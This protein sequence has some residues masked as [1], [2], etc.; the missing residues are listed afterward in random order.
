MTHLTPVSE[1]RANAATSASYEMLLQ[2]MGTQKFGPTVRDSVLSVAPGVRRIYLFEA[3]GRGHSAVRYFFGEQGLVDIFP[4]YRRWYLRQDPVWDACNAAPR[5]G[6]VAVQ[7]VRPADIPGGDFRRRI[8]D[9]PGI[10]ERVSVVQRGADGWRGMNVAR[11]ASDGVF[12]Q[13]EIHSLVGL[14]CLVLPMIALIRARQPDVAHLTVPE[15]EERFA[16]HCEAL[17]LRERQVCARAAVGMGV[18][19]TATELGIGNSSVLTYRQRAYQRLGVASPIE[20]RAL[21]TH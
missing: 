10:V 19:A 8:F 20:L 4:A 9:E 13:G 7:T 14:A 5:R 15:L 16:G 11:H 1:W 21:V 17:T 18:E 6:D 12:S 2:T 3:T